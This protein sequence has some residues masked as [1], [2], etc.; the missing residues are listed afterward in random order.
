MRESDGIILAYPKYLFNVP[1]KLLSFL[2]RLDL[3]H[4]F[5]RRIESDYIEDLRAEQVLPP[6]LEGKPCCLLVVTDPEE[7]AE[8]CLNMVGNEVRNLGMK[9][10]LFDSQL[11]AHAIGKLRG[12]IPKDEKGIEDCTK[13]LRKLINSVS[14]RNG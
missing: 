8:N 1:T 13:L 6:P 11:G 5:R 4:H 12:D 3:M 2:E 10:I 9:L 14:P 7:K